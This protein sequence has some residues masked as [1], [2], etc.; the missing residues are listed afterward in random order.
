MSPD[1]KPSDDRRDL[2]STPIKLSWKSAMRIL[3]VDDETDIRE[4]L[5]AMLVGQKYIVDTAADG[6]EA[7]DRIFA[8]PYDLI[9]LDIMLPKRD[10]LS[11]LREIRRAEIRMPVLLLTARSAINDKIKGLDQ[12]ADDYLA[13][14]FFRGGAAGACAGLAQKGYGTCHALPG[15]W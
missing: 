1:G 6:E 4:Q 5:G 15:N 11:V 14:P 9:I 8:Q 13:K 3:L 10:G 7:L 2:K 12:G